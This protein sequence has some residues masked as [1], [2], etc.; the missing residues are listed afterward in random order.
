MPDLGMW[1]QE[2]LWSVVVSQSIDKSVSS[3]FSERLCFK[4]LYGE[5]TEDVSLWFLHSYTCPHVWHTDT[6]THSHTHRHTQTH[7]DT[8]T[9][10]HTHTHT[11][12]HNVSSVRITHTDYE[13]SIAVLLILIG[14]TELLIHNTNYIIILLSQTRLFLCIFVILRD[15]YFVSPVTPCIFKTSVIPFLKHHPCMQS[16][17][18][19]FHFQTGIENKT[20]DEEF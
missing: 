12:T 7:T 14:D 11:C 3:K 18:W 16:F 10:T 17:H 13:Y 15:F 8:H 20:G 2:Y 1:K 6:Q 4:T 19:C 9:H 5:V